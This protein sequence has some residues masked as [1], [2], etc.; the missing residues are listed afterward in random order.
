[1]E[2]GEDRLIIKETCGAEVAGKN[3]FIAETTIFR[4]IAGEATLLLNGHASRFI[5]G[6]NFI[7]LDSAHICVDE[8]SA[9]FSYITIVFGRRAFN[10]IYTHID[11]A[12]L[13][14]L[15]SSAPDLGALDLYKQSELTLDK[16]ILLNDDAMEYKRQI[17]RN[18]IFC[19]I[20]EMGKLSHNRVFEARTE[21]SKFVDSLIARFIILCREHH[22]KHKDIAFYSDSLSI[23]RRYLHTIVVRKMHVTPKEFIDGY[24][25]TSAKRLLLETTKSTQQIAEELNFP[26]Q[27]TFGQFFKRLLT[28]SPSQFRSQH[29]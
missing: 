12:L 22:T 27:S 10:R 4:C 29:K 14:C 9:D 16:I 2:N 21:G 18:L 28:L 13:N 15:K 24:I 1:M 17:M 26:D 23:S 25:I 7:V 11:V 5:K 19:Y 3:I 20:Y 8:C 6:T